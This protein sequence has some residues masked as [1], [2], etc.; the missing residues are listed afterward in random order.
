MR[1]A[2]EILINSQQTLSWTFRELSLARVRA[3]NPLVTTPTHLEIPELEI[4]VQE[5]DD[6][7][8]PQ[9]SNFS[10]MLR[11]QEEPAGSTTMPSGLFEALENTPLLL[12]PTPLPMPDSTS[13]FPFIADISSPLGDDRPTN[14]P[15]RW[16]AMHEV[17]VT[18][19]TAIPAVMLALLLNLLDAI[20]YGIIIFPASSSL[21]PSSASQSG[22]SMFFARCERALSQLQRHNTNAIA[23]AHSFPKWYT[24]WE[25][26][27]SREL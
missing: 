11:R 20:S 5:L 22:I 24:L 26:P 16:R 2:S 27:L 9:E 10:K 12:N 18:G 25:A 21:L 1:K 15:H 8:S 6:S 13:A 17:V 7:T 19:F 4:G 23:S 3:S 14:K